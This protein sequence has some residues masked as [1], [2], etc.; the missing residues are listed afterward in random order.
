[1]RIFTVAIASKYRTR[2]QES[3]Q[4]ATQECIHKKKNNKK[5]NYIIEVPNVPS[6]LVDHNEICEMLNENA[7]TCFLRNQAEQSK[8]KSGSKLR[9]I[10]MASC[11]RILCNY[12]HHR[13]PREVKNITDKPK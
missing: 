13:V 7:V 10:S 9:F 3:N 1:M 4:L 11:D 5:S 12:C 8:L 2:T 6:V